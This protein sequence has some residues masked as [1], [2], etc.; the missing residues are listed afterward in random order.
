MKNFATVLVLLALVSL[1][2]LTGAETQSAA[3]SSA[4][5]LAAAALAADTAE[6][7][8][9]LAGD[10]SALPGALDL[11]SGPA[12]P[13]E[14]CTSHSD[15]PAGQLCCYPCGIDGC[16]FVCMTPVRGRCPMFP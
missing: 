12:S 7:L 5:A 11:A 14:T 3:A 10:P 15:C 6:F 4:G 1:A 9:E 2:P 13:W 8:A 16:D